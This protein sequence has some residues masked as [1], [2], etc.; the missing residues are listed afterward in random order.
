L[1]SSARNGKSDANNA[2][3]NSRQYSDLDIIGDGYFFAGSAE[4][5]DGFASAAS[6][7]PS[8]SARGII[9]VLVIGKSVFGFVS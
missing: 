3:Q 8:R 6:I 9:I 4:T 7:T 5:G 1:L 2:E